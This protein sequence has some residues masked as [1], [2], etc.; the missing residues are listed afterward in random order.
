MAGLPA[1]AACN[2]F[3]AQSSAP[4]F[5]AIQYLAELETGDGGA[6]EISLE[7]AVLDSPSASTRQRVRTVALL[8]LLHGADPVVA[9]V[10]LATRGKRFT[11]RIDWDAGVGAAHAAAVASLLAPDLSA[12]W[13]RLE[14]VVRLSAAETDRRACRRALLRVAR[15]CWSGERE[16]ISRRDLLSELEREPPLRP[17]TGRR[18]RAI[19]T[20]P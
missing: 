17:D 2:L 9:H 12:A 18:L 1:G 19:L 7:T 14:A 6:A 20:E 13:D 11:P 3:L 16:A 4:P 8:S 15:R 5:G 10:D